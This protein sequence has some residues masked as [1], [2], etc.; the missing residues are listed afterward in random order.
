MDTNSQKQPPKEIRQNECYECFSII[1]KVGGRIFL[2]INFFIDT[3]QPT[4]QRRINVVSTFW[5]TLEI[6]LIRRGKRKKI[7]NRSFIVAQDWYKIGVKRWNNVKSTMHIVDG[8]V[9][10]SCATSFQRCFN[11]DMTLSQ[12]YFNVVSTSF[13]AI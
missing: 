8:T 11:G 1:L 13:K 10:Q 4:F 3:T 12:R 6:T 9:S 5:I 7:R 2:K